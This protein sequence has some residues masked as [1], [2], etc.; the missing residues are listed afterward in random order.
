MT[1]FEFL[2]LKND[3]NVASKRHKQKN[4]VKKLVFLLASWRSMTKIEGSGSISQ[5]HVSPDPDPPQNVM[6]PQHWFPRSPV[7]LSS[8][9]DAHQMTVY[10]LFLLYVIHFCSP[11]YRSWGIHYLFFDSIVTFGCL[12]HFC[13]GSKLF[14]VWGWVVSPDTIVLTFSCCHH[15]RLVC[16]FCTLPLP[17]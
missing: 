6:D 1:L 5:R 14:V 4:C 15:S 17:D 16:L 11:R 2:S 9:K 3:V 8:G 13:A 7:L 12:F 10:C